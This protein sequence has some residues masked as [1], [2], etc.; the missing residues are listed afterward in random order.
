M[1]RVARSKLGEVTFLAQAQADLLPFADAHFDIVFS[2]SAFHYMTQPSRVLTE[3]RR[4]L[5]PRGHLV[6]TDWCDDYLVC[7]VCDL[8]LRVSNRAHYRTYTRVECADLIRKAGSDLV[9]VDRYRT[10]WLWGLM[11]AIALKPAE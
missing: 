5:K 2:V 7:K 6:I 4:V 10:S 8:V 3:F 1:L 9:G 11:T